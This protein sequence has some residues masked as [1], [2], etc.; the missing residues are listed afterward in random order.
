LLSPKPLRK[1]RATAPAAETPGHR[2]HTGKIHRARP[3]MPAIYAEPAARRWP[4]GI[5]Q[6]TNIN[7]DTPQEDGHTMLGAMQDWPLLTSSILDYAARYHG[8]REIV[9]R[10]VEGPI[11][12]TDYATLVRRAGQ[13]AGALR[14][15]GIREGDRVATLAWNTHRHMEAWYG[16]SGI[17]AVCHTINPRLFPDQIAYIANHAEDT[18]ILVDPPFLPLLEGMAAQ[19][20]RVRGYVVLTDRAHMPA[21]TLPDAL[22]YEEWIAGEDADFA[23]PALDERAASGLCYTSGTTGKPKGVLYSHR[24]CVVHALATNG[25]DVVGLRSVDC[26]M[27]IVPMYHVNAWGIVYGAPMVGAKLVLPGARMDAESLYA[28]LEDEQVTFTAAVPTIWLSLIQLMERTGTRLSSLERVAIGGSAAPRGMIETLERT[29]GVRVLHAWGMT[30]T[31]SLATISVPKGGMPPLSP[32]QQLDLQVKQGR[33]IYTVMTKITD[34]AGH[35]LPWDGRTFGHLMVRG[36][37]VASAYFKG[38]GGPV[39]DADGWFDTGDVATIDPDGFVQITD[40]AKDVIKSGGEWI[41]SI[42]LENVAVGHP[43]VAEAAVIGIAHPKWDE[44]PLLIV[45][46]KPGQT[47]TKENVLAYLDGRVAKWWMPDDV[48][49]VDDIPHTATGKIQK[50]ALRERFKDYVLPSI[51]KAAGP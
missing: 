3:V 43:G 19:L 17:G 15:F 50:V 4:R 49:F 20:P 14:R 21:T 33:P 48:V 39:L 12:R 44:R 1:A 30:E 38:E 41:S 29:Y 2:R 40:R 28:L 16:I 5:A 35:D 46:A 45:I 23:W 7:Q 37:A 6:P 31:S 36:S 34:D 9:T 32:E 27:P 10:A 18:L 11:T 22:C 13:L 26:A 51:A 47:V 24:S 8:K 42:E 25:A